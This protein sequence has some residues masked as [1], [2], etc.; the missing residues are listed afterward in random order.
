MGRLLRPAL[1][2]TL[3]LA[4][5]VALTLVA[6]ITIGSTGD[7]PAPDRVVNGGGAPSDL[8]P[9]AIADPAAYIP[10]L[11]NRLRR[12]PLDHRGWSTLVLA[13]VEQ[14]RISA[15]PTYYVK[16]DKAL[17]RAARLA[18][19]DSVMLTASAALENARHDFRAAVTSADEAVAANPTSAAAHAYR[20]D[21]LTELGRYAEARRAAVRADNLSPGPSTFARLSYAAELRGD[22][23]EAT[24][25]MRLSRNAA[26]TS[27]AS[28]AFAA[29]HLGELARIQGDRA[30]AARH[31]GAAIEADPDFMPAY[32]GRA[33]LA[34]A[35]G[36]IAAAEKDY[37]EVVRRLPLQEYLVELGELYLA[38]DRPEL[39]DAQFAVAAASAT[40]AR[41]NG[42]LVD[43]ET[44]FFEAD[45]GSSDAA[46]E[47]ARAEW[48]YRQSVFSA[49]ALAWALHVKGRDVEALRYA[50]QAT[51][52]GTQDAR[53]IF[54][55]G[56][57]EAALGMDAPGRKHLQAALAIDNGVAPWREELARDLLQTVDATP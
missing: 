52:L 14:A 20:A 10:T 11:Q 24:R 44:A 57:I 33:R 56:A 12:T 36:D 27:A 17:S 42:V 55:R 40:L 50:R 34:V 5:A 54:H 8:G 9:G 13:Y 35:R 21:A 51:R 7:S 2:G 25:L 38:T 4:L 43:L 47:A 29:Y 48:D 37:A 26:G 18:P 23:V 31:Y 49:D 39:A 15:D 22:L 3:A 45:H 19:E 46:L 6:S 28:F 53:M 30:A 16:A 1:Y 41:S 32:A